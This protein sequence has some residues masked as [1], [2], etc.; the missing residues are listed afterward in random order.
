MTDITM[1]QFAKVYERIC[2]KSDLSPDARS[3]VLCCF[4]RFYAGLRP[5]PIPTLPLPGQIALKAAHLASNEL[6]ERKLGQKIK[7]ADGW[8][9]LIDIGHPLFALPKVKQSP[10]LAYTSKKPDV[11]THDMMTAWLQ[12][13]RDTFGREYDKQPQ[14][15]VR[16][17][18]VLRRLGGARALQAIKEYLQAN[19][20][21]PKKVNTL[22]FYLKYGRG[23]ASL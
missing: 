6:H 11:T 14:D 9:F 23:T 10:L 4:L 1:A 5:L 8:Y 13:F 20:S 17:R 21:S 2:A 22:S 18:Y 16:Y 3:L 7:K 19:S 12:G 15:L